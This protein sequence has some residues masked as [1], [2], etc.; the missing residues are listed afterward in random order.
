MYGFKTKMEIKWI[1]TVVYWLCKLIHFI[2]FNYSRTAVTQTRN[3]CRNV[4]KVC[5][6]L[7]TQVSQF[8][9]EKNQI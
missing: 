9:R 8:Q 3:Y 4:F 5:E 1:D 6:V 2:R 7:A